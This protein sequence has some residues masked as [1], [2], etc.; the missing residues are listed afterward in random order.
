MIRYIVI[1]ALLFVGAKTLQ[2]QVTYGNEWIDYSRPHYTFKVASSGI[3]RITYQN[4]QQ[5]GIPVSSIQ[6]D[7]FQLFGKEREQPIF[8]EDGG[9]SSF[10]PG[11]YIEFY[12]ERN[13][14]WLDS[15]LY[16][17]EDHIGNPAYSLYNDTLHYYLTWKPGNHK[18]YSEETDVNFSTF[19]P[20]PYI[21]NKSEVDWNSRYYGGFSLLNSYSSFFCGR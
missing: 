9:D 18:R 5:A 1:L 3:Y 20:A 7:Q 11:D 16:E 2:A 4:M 17:E 14:G 8:V 10:D 21:L 15:I 6:P 13:D 19:N 12:A